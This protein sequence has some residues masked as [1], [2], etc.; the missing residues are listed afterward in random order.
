MSS[1]NADSC[2]S[3]ALLYSAFLGR[4]IAASNRDLVKVIEEGSFRRDLYYR[5]NVLTVNSP[6][7][8]ARKEDIIPT[9][10]HIISRICAKLGKEVPRVDESAMQALVHYNWPGNVREIENVL[11]R[12]VNVA[13]GD[14]IDLA[15]LPH[16]FVRPRYRTSAFTGHA[17][18]RCS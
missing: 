2:V 18:S 12:A 1:K 9:V 4:I 10:K 16:Q 13:D 7:V 11:E 3:V 5:L 8:R 14:W 6:P 15:D 17:H